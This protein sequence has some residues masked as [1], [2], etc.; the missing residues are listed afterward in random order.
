VPLY[1]LSAV[2]LQ[3]RLN[4]DRPSFYLMNKRVD[5]KIVFNFLGAE[6]MVRRVRPNPAMLLAHTAT[7]NKGVLRGIT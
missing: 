4:K 6:L 7:P 3:I 2:R 5:S 1:L